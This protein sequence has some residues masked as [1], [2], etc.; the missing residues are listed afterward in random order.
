[1]INFLYIIHD[2]TIVNT[3]KITEKLKASHP[4]VPQRIGILEKLIDDQ[5]Q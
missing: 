2:I 1:M 4:D 3:P 5:K